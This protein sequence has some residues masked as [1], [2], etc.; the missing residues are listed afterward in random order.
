MP[1]PTAPRTNADAAA[2][3]TRIRQ[4]A[5]TLGA[6][7]TA[8]PSGVVTVRADFTPGDLAGYVS[9][10]DACAT[11]IAQVPQTGPGSTWGTTSDTVGGY[12]AVRTGV[13][14]IKMSG[15]PRRLARQLAAGAR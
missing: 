13:C 14:R 6:T 11:V 2:L 8:I 3:A 1:A 7:V 10:E 5:A 12:A 9:A 15:V 4:L